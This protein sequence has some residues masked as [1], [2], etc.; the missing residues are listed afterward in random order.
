MGAVARR[1]TQ[2]SKTYSLNNTLGI[3]HHIRIRDSQ[4]QEPELLQ[5][6]VAQPI[7]GLIMRI[8]INLND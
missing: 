5:H 4:H 7:L 1:T 2:G 3:G 8:A 6:I